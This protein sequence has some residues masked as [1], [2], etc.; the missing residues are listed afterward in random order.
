MIPA[1]ETVSELRSLSESYLYNRDEDSVSQMVTKTMG[2]CMESKQH[3]A[4]YTLDI[5]EL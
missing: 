2:W 3:S 1:Y 4:R 5:L